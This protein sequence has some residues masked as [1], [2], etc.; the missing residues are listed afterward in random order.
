[1]ATIIEAQVDDF[2]TQLPWP[3]SPVFFVREE[4]DVLFPLGRYA[5]PSRP[6]PQ[7]NPVQEVELGWGP[8]GQRCRQREG[9]TFCGAGP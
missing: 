6:K 9:R 1:M 5:W 2:K 8:F 7:G 4:D 3:T